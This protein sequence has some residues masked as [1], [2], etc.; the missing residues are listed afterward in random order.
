VGKIFDALEKFGKERGSPVFDRVKDSDYEILMQFDEATGRINFVDSNAAKDFRVIK[1]LKTFRLINDDGTLTAAGRAKYEEMLRQSKEQ[2]AA[3]AAQTIEKFIFDQ[4]ETVPPGFEKAPQKDWALVMNYDRQTGNLLKYDPE[5]GELDENS[6]SLLQNSAT[7]QRLIDNQM[8]LPGGWL[9]QEA[10]SVCSRIQEKLRDEKLY[11]SAKQEEAGPAEK[12]EHISEPPDPVSQADMIVLQDYDQQTLKLNMENPLI[13]KNPEIL[14]RF[15]ENGLIDA[16]GKLSATALVRCR[17]LAHWKNNFEEKE[18][19]L[20]K[21]GSSI[22]EKLQTLAEKNK[23][24]EISEEAGEEKLKIIHL[25]KDRIEDNLKDK[26]EDRIETKIDTKREEEKAPKTIDNFIMSLEVPAELPKFVEES[27]ENRFAFGRAPAAYARGRI[28]QDLITINSPQS[29]EAEQ[30]KILR[31]N[32]LFSESGKTPRSVMVTSVLPGEGKSFVASNLAVSIARHVN[33]NVLLIDC[34]LRRP[35]IHLRFGF[36]NVAGLGDYL[37][38]STPLEQLL[39]KTGIKNLTILPAGKLPDNPSELL[40]SE[41]MAALLVEVAARYNDRLIIIDSPPPKM[42]AESGALARYVDG[43]L[44][45][46]KY[47]STPKSSVTELIAKLG[48]NKIIGAVVNNFEAGAFRYQKKY[49]G[50]TYYT[51]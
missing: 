43:I 23:P 39:V 3:I 30:F 32:L 20:Q 7:M 33:W 34:D 22:G 10:K 6:R 36:K 25:K 11:P 15:Q 49:Y 19:P 31:T 47:G 5:T 1:R 21:P 48:K 26:A 2:A 35:S 14:T 16:E 4:K 27:S 24:R 28:N 18:P 9:T 46:V 42:T 51:K 38:T 41:R 8:I 45:V 44:L 12:P 13:V 29:F 17:I 37:T 40:S 50:G